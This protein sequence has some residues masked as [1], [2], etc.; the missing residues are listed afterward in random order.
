[1]GIRTFDLDTHHKNVLNR[2]NGITRSQYRVAWQSSL[3]VHVYA[4][5]WPRRDMTLRDAT[6]HI[7]AGRTVT[8]R[9]LVAVNCNGLR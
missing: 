1:M 4:D 2:A 3:S 8:K 9:R 7:V 6:L 5:V